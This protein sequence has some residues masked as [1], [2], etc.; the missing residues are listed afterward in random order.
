M[1]QEALLVLLLKVFLISGFVALAGWVGLYTWLTGGAAWRNP[2]GQ[3]LVIKSLLVACTFLVIALG[4]FFPWFGEHP[5][6][7]GWI[8]FALIGGVTPVMW[9]RSAVWVR[10]H[11]AGKLHQDDSDGEGQA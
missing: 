9:W 11:R 4:A 6:V 5:L 1:T 2:V 10:L 8:D 7:T 3:T